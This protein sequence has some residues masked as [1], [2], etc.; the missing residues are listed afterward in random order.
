MISSLHHVTLMTG[1]TAQPL[2]SMVTEDVVTVCQKLLTAALAG[3]YPVLPFDNGKWT[4]SAAAQGQN[5]V[6]TLWASSRHPLP[7]LTTGVA[8]DPGSARNLWRALHDTSL[9]PLV[10]DPGQ[11]PEPPWIADRIEPAFPFEAALWTGDFSRCLAWA[12]TD[13]MR[14]RKEPEVRT[15]PDPDRPAGACA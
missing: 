4:L 12:W 7:I 15:S 8:L 10:T 1:H 5:L 13:E 3:R 9:L 2:R 11:P 6:A 14:G